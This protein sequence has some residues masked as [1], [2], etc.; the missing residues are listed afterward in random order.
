M[1]D[2]VITFV[3]G[4]AVGIVARGVFHTI[5][6]RYNTVKVYHNEDGKVVWFFPV[7]GSCNAEHID[8][9]MS[10]KWFVADIGEGCCLYKDEFSN[11]HCKQ[12]K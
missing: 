3:V 9:Q 11:C 5:S 1:L 6:F 4:F 8:A 2:S 10:C 7:K 12:F